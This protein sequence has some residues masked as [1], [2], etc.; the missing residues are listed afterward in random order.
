MLRYIVQAVLFVA[1][2]LLFLYTSR[3]S[4]VL[5]DTQD[6]SKL[7]ECQQ[8]YDSLN[9][10]VQDLEA[11]VKILNKYLIMKNLEYIEACDLTYK[12]H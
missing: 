7:P 3:S 10:E 1:I 12:S 6:C 5:I 2:I 4:D 8:T 9:K 11:K